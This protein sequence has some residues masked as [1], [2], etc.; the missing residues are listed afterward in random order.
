[1]QTLMGFRIRERR[2]ELGLTQTEL[3]KRVGV[4]PSYLNLIEKNKRR[5]AGRLLGEIGRALSL[6]IDALDGSA[7]RRL[8]AR[9]LELARDPDLSEAGLDGDESAELIAR[10]PAFARAAARAHA[11]YRAGIE[12]LRLMSDRLAHDPVLAERVHAMLTEITALRST[13]EILAGADDVSPTQRRRFETIMREQAVR[14]SDTGAGLA[15]YFD[16]TIES[17]RPP[18]TE[19]D[20]EEILARHADLTDRVE[21]EAD[22]VRAT[23][24]A[25]LDALDRAARAQLSGPDAPPGRQID[26]ASRL[27][28]AATEQVE[29]HLAPALTA[30]AQSRLHDADGQPA[31]T[32]QRL[33]AE[34]SRR[35][36][37]AL[38]APRDAFLALGGALEWDLA[39]LARAYDG[40]AGLI[41][42]RLAVLGAPQGPAPGVAPLAAH[43]E[44]DAS[45]AVLVRRGDLDLL[46]QPRQFECPNWPAFARALHREG[47]AAQRLAAADGLEIVA[48]AQT[49]GPRHGGT[50]RIHLTAIDARAAA[51]TAYRS[52]LSTDPAPVGPTCRLCAHRDCAARRS[53]PAIG[54]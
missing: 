10:F 42:R 40:D 16:E 35:A 15:R 12:D 2:R 44:L 19:D 26:R 37:D 9:L 22:A 6:S 34:L 50:D 7:E 47:V 38:R 36:A 54:N 5:A 27:D 31:E 33:E 30:L 20:V 1:M 53:P 4:S 28:R 11:L 32:R 14:L 24:D 49:G 25:D 18:S 51:G 39:A 41:A 48:I 23:G 45:G 17:R 21:R 13:A 3:A 52:L 8:Q 46:P 29:R 43:A